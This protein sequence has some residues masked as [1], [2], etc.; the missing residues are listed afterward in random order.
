MSPPVPDPFAALPAR[1]DA[2]V[3]AD[4]F[5]L[6]MAEAARV[7]MTERTGP[8]RVELRS[9]AVIVG[10]LVPP[11]ADA[12]ERHLL[13]V[14]RAG[15]RLLVFVDAVTALVGASA[16]L[17]DES[18]ARPVRTLASRLRECWTSGSRLRVMMRDGRWIDGAIALVAADHVE[19]IVSGE[20]WVVP[21]RAAEAWDL[22]LTA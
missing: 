4:A 3:R 21:F 13:V 6:F 14:D 22:G 8:A 7:R 19:L 5:E 12:V 16:A 9:G 10:A 15:R 1:S 18:S 11:D 2:D 20:R 17:R